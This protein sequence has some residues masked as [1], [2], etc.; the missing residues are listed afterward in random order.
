MWGLNDLIF[1]SYAG[2]FL[3][4]PLR[5]R[6]LGRGL[7]GSCSCLLLSPT[8]RLAGLV[9]LSAALLGLAGLVLLTLALPLLGLVIVLLLPPV[10][11]VLPV[12][13]LEGRKTGILGGGSGGC[14][15]RTVEILV[16]HK[17]ATSS[18]R[19]LNGLES[20]RPGV[21]QIDRITRGRVNEAAPS[22]GDGI[23]IV[24]QPLDRV[25][26]EHD[27]DPDDRENYYT[28]DG[29]NHVV[30][31]DSRLLSINLEKI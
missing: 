8:L 23:R 12:S 27:G 10:G 25:F 5:R 1:A 18:G 17:P 16:L 31:H 15:C 24:A 28:N 4:L 11:A 14:R 13:A 19:S 20:R 6:R 21:G 26:F 30:I 2:F 29:E 7:D 3:V 9:L 22:C